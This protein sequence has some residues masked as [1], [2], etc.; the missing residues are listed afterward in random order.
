MLIIRNKQKAALGTV[1]LLNFEHEMALHLQKFTPI[2]YKTLGEEG[3]RK[4]I[5]LGV[6][7]AEKYGLS[8]HDP[9]RFYL[10]L[11]F[12]FGSDLDTD[13]QLSWVSQILTDPEIKDQTAR[14]A[15]LY[16]KTM[17]YVD[18]VAGPDYEYARESLERA[19]QQS[20]KKLTV[21]RGDLGADIV[22]LLKMIYSQKCMY[23]GESVL[24][25]L[26]QHGKELT[27]QYSIS[28][29]AGV[30]IFVWC[31]FILGHGFHSDPQFPWVEELLKD[32]NITDPDKRIKMLHSKCVVYFNEV[33]S[34][35]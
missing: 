6:G 3:V 9:V 16:D 13:S 1:V 28:S 20:Y 30:I 34:T 33:L 12:M 27:K 18:K 32:Q 4:V 29:E 8:N 5:R 23:V 24:L 26:I 15:L 25:S 31:M 7:R 11:M 2:Q 21:S 17:D 22:A 14:V 35:P 19:S 10:E